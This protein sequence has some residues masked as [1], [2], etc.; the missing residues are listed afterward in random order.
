MCV[1]IVLGDWHAEHFSIPEIPEW[2]N[3]ATALLQAGALRCAP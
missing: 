2:Q 3:T 1:P